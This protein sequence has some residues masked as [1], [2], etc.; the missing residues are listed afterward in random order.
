MDNSKKSRCH[1]MFTH[2]ASRRTASIMPGQGRVKVSRRLAHSSR[3]GLM[4]VP[5]AAAV[6]GAYCR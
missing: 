3:I 4:A 6:V 5:G 1:R 2:R